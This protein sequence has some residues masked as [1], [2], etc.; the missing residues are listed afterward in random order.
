MRE[1]REKGTKGRKGVETLLDRKYERQGK[2][3]NT[4]RESVKDRQKQI[5]KGKKTERKK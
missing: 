5:E 1:K 4:D 3:V 2:K